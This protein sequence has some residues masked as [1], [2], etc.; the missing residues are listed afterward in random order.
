MSA[1]HARQQ[2]Q[3]SRRHALLFDLD[4]TLATTEHLHRAAYDKLLADQGRMLD[5]AT[6]AT[7][8]RGRSGRDVTRF[9]FPDCDELECSRLMERKERTF[10][11][12]AATQGLLPTPGVHM[13]LEWA[14]ARGV[15]TALVTNAPRA[16]AEMVIKVIGMA[17]AF[18]VV[19]S[20]SELARGKPHPDPYVTALDA[21]AL[22]AASALAVEDSPVGIASARAANL[23]VIGIAGETWDATPIHGAAIVVS[24]MSDPRLIAFLAERFDLAA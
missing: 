21:L 8:V 7:H 4:G 17:S 22:D 9:L 2:A 23:D 19:V 1:V 10:R 20:A 24:D 14:R 13:L 15:A 3:G 12:L 11:E 18:D 6:F 16:N 5:P